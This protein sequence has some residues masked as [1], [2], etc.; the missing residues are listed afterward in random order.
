MQWLIF[1][2]TQ[3][4]FIERT[5]NTMSVG[6][7]RANRAI[8]YRRMHVLKLV[9]SLVVDIFEWNEN[10]NLCTVHSDKGGRNIKLKGQPEKFRWF[11]HNDN[12]SFPAGSVGLWAARIVYRGYATF[13]NNHQMSKTI[14]SR[15]VRGHPLPYM[16]C[17]VDPNKTVA[18]AVPMHYWC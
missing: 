16:L 1:R 11:R 13:L 5:P 17:Y 12:T 8:L 18:A 3:T 2:G 14:R 10:N 15:A 6:Y 9:P 7:T 4:N